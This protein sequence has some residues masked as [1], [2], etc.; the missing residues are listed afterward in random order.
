MAI[1]DIKKTGIAFTIRKK[2][3]RDMTIYPLKP[4]KGGG[5]AV[6]L[7]P[8]VYQ[9][10]Q[11]P[12]VGLNSKS[13]RSSHNICVRE[14]FYSPTETPA[15]LANPRRGVFASAVLAWQGLS[16][17]DK[18]MYNQKAMGKHFTGYCQFLHEYLISH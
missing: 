2:L 12:Y 1:I 5:F 11:R 4:Y 16:S 9:M 3:K 18:K 15:R 13:P 6:T 10:R 17:D 7:L 14:K 8:G